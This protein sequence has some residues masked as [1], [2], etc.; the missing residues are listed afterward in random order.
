MPASDGPR[1]EFVRVR[2]DDPRA[3]PL[4]D[5][6]EREYDTR[7][8]TALGEPASAELARYPVEA[9]APPTGAFVLLLRDG[10]TI[11]G[12]ALKAFD[13]TTAE[14]KRIWTSSAHRRQGLALRVVT[15]LEEEA[16]RLGYST[17]YLTTGPLQ[18]EAV[19]LYLTAGYTP[20]YDVTQ[21]PEVVLLHGFAKTLTEQPLDVARI[22][23]AHDASFAELAAS[24]PDGGAG[25]RAGILGRAS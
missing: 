25:L 13:A 16:G 23:V 6:L 20:L 2:A 8:G 18:P 12:G 15:E 10:T 22:Q 4:L 5:E 11:A 21:P 19:R 24:L 14:L 7:Y 3:R 17:V 9:F 1:D